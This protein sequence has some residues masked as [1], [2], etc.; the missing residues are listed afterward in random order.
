MKN[1]YLSIILLQAFFG[2]GTAFCA[3][4]IGRELF[5]LLTGLIASFFTASY[6]YSIKHDVALQETSLYTFLTALSI[7]FLFK[8]FSSKSKLYC[9]LAGLFLA[10]AILTR[11]TITAFSWTCSPAKQPL[12]QAV[13]FFSYFPILILGLI[14]MIL[15][16]HQWKKHGIIYLLFFSFALVS[17]IFWSHTSHRSHLDIYLIIFSPYT[18]RWS[19]SNYAKRFYSHNHLIT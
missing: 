8:A 1:N 12:F 4:L 7:F 14:G 18:L 10:T 19:S 13:Y 3:F 17:A 5:D 6:P 9:G 2:T 15:N 16:R 11:N